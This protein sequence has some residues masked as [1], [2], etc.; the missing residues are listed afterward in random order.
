ME[1]DFSKFLREFKD[2]IRHPQNYGKLWNANGFAEERNILCADSVTFYISTLKNR[3]EMASYEG[4]S[5]V[6]SRLGGTIVSEAIKGKGLAELIAMKDDF[7]A[8]LYGKCENSPILNTLSMA[9][10]KRLQLHPSRHSCALLPWGA[11]VSAFE[12]SIL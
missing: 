10:A 6:L 3:V 1:D 9:F 12:N 7:T 8:I 11:A 5:C 4:Q 2:H